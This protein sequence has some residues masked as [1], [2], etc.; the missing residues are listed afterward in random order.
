MQVYG[1]QRPERIWHLKK[2]KKGEEDHDRWKVDEAREDPTRN[3]GPDER[4]RRRQ[5]IRG[6]NEQH[7]LERKVGEV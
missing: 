3:D 7:S 5:P 4:K 1:H 6:S 2:K